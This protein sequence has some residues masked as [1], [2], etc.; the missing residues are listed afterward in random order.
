MA[1]TVDD[2]S[3]TATLAD[4][5]NRA[6]ALGQRY[7]D[8]VIDGD[9][10]RLQGL[11]AADVRFRA[12]VPSRTWEASTAAGARR[13]VDGWFGESVDRVLLQSSVD[14]LSDRLVFSFRMELTEGGERKVVEQ[15]VAAIVG[16]GVFDDVA[17][18][19]SGSRPAAPGTRAA[20]AAAAILDATGLSCATLTPTIRAAVLELDPGGVL[21]II[22]DDP[23]A[24]ADLAAWTRLTR[25]ELLGWVPGPGGSRRFSVRRSPALATADSKGG[26]H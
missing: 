13:I 1:Q 26:T 25:H 23:A 22:S 2:L 9:F 4:G 5:A 15:H 19:C 11:L 20:I 24:E 8:A 10:D 14:V 6:R 18:V 12:L 16:D 17:L 7:I 3:I 21:E